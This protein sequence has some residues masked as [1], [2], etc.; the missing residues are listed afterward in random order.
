MEPAELYDTVARELGITTREGELFS[1]QRLIDR[2][3]DLVQ[4][5]FHKLI[6]ILYRT[7]VSETRLRTLLQQHTGEDAAVLIT[8]LIIE[9][10][11]QKIKSRQQFRQPDEN[12]NED[13]KW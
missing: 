10:Q 13:E 11:L 6:S 9:R 3:N 4:T 7:D 12:I 2:I 1:R 8:D 5:D